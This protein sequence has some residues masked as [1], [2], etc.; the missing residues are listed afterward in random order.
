VT[1]RRAAFLDRDGTI[2]EDV[3]YIARPDD[4]RLQSGAAEAIRTLNERGIVVVVITN[5]SGIARGMFSES[6]YEAVRTRIDAVL[7]LDGARIDASYHCPHYPDI[8][9]PCECRKPGTLLY[10]RAVADLDIDAAASMFAGD[11]LRDVLP[12]GRYGGT[13][14]LVQAP[15]TPDAEVTEARA[16]G[17]A[18]VPSLLDAVRR[19]Q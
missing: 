3:R 17:V 15:S 13:A 6:D 12:A 9:G 16:C 11:R 18:I 5:Q 10:D 19:F 4:V 8:S 7:A 14:Y 2:I 1:A